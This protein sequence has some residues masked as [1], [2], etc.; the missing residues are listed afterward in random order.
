MVKKK[1]K[2][3]AIILIIFS[4]IGMIHGLISASL[5]NF[6]TWLLIGLWLIF[7][8]KI[9]NNI[10]RHREFNS[11]HNTAFFVIIPLLIGV[12][13]SIWGSYTGI[14]GENLISGSNFY[15]SLWS[16]IFGLP[17]VIY[18]SHSIYRCFKKYNVIYFGTK[19]VK[20]KA[21][22]FILAI[23]VIIA[24]ISYWIAFYNVSEFY[25]PLTPLRFSLDLNLLLLLIITIFNLIIF[26]FISNRSNIPELTRDY[27]AQRT[28]R[29]NNL[30][31]PPTQ[32]A[33]TRTRS[34]TIQT[35]STTRTTRTTTTTKPRS[36]RT[37]PTSYSQSTRKK[38]TKSV[39]TQRVTTSPKVRDFS[40][41]KP[42]GSNISEEDFKCIFCFRLPKLPDDKNKGIVICPNCRYPA[43]ADEFKDW[44][45]T[46][47]LCSRCSAPIP[48]GFR[49]N[50]RIITT[51]N[52][53]IIYRH[54]LNHK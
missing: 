17:F 50:P 41:Y 31:T 53:I 46:S 19:S 48:S 5:N 45:K 24:I 26:G 14:L 27:I 36:S 44:M 8:I 51:K 6:L 3:L 35:P 29:I 16:L 54:F 34:R 30:T 33:S 52:Y 20:A 4:V 38:T 2:A 25:S 21:L 32:T 28:R 49:R 22:G 40:K 10:K 9:Y 15:F 7:T 37:T 23:S 12:F 43:H 42:K 11:P 39:R 47:N 1:Q 18:G 13:Y